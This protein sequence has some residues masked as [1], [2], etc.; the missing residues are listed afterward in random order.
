MSEGFSQGV[1]RACPSNKMKNALGTVSFRA[2][3]F[4]V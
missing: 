2:G 4:A 1:K 3:L